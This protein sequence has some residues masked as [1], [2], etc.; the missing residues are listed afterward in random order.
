MITYN[1]K[2]YENSNIYAIFNYNITMFYY[3]NTNI[4]HVQQ[5][6]L[7]LTNKLY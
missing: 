2:V 5:F 3:L 1:K 4:C 7:E 6:F